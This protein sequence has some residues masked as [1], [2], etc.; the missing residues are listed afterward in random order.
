M[1]REFLRV[2]MLG[3]GFIAQKYVKLYAEYPRSRLVAVYDPLTEAASEV[4]KA[5]R[6]NVAASE[7][8]LLAQDIDAVVISTPNNLHARQT[9][10]AL[11]A[12]KHV[13]LQK[14][15]TVTSAQAMDLIRIAAASQRQLGI[16]MNSLDNPVFRDIKAM[17]RAGTLGRIGSISAQLANG[18]SPR[19]RADSVTAAWR[20]SKAA[21]GGGSF[22]MLACHYINLCQWLLD[23]PIVS[24]AAR[25][26]NLMSE[27]IEGDDV[28]H[29]ITEFR[30]GVLGVIG[31][32]WCVA[33]EQFSNSRQ[34]GFAGLH[35]ERPDQ[36]EGRKSLP[37][38]S[39]HLH[40]AEHADFHGG[41]ASTGDGRLAQ[42]AQPAP[43]V[44][45]RHPQGKARPSQWRDGSKGYARPRGCLPLVQSSGGTEAVGSS[46]S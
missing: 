25:G 41:P 14:P 33:G 38:R 7:E 21:V 23:D 22:A 31:A 35:R 2:G 30:S 44:R 11:R 39:D 5:H 42:S 13:L 32:A 36:H 26:K 4:A 24:V 40:G 6:A 28:M 18:S 9:A 16:Y 37:R 8:D 20:R 12:G 43:A 27:H 15:M 17:I 45:R 10:A 34:R 46:L 29:A 19:W 3:V 1:S